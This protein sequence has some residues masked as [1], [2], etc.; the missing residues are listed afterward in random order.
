LIPDLLP[1]LTTLLNAVPVGLAAFDLD[2]CCLSINAAFAAMAGRSV[3]SCVGLHAAGGLPWATEATLRILGAVAEA[4][5]SCT[6]QRVRIAPTGQPGDHQDYD[7]GYH[8]ARDASGTIVGV[9]VLVS[10]VPER[11]AGTPKP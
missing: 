6:G 2:L 4:G 11:Q 3:E 10:E 9:T 5:E 7:V 1:H 8:P